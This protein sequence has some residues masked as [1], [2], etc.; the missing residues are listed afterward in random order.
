MKKWLLVASLLSIVILLIG[1]GSK[2]IPQAAIDE[3]IALNHAGDTADH[4][5]IKTFSD[6]DDYGYVM[7]YIKSLPGEFTSLEDAIP[8][9][10][11]YSL[12]V[13]EVIVEIL[14]KY[15]INKDLS[16]W[17]QLPLEDGGV[18]VLGHAE[19][20]GNKFVDFERHQP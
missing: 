3:V 18:T 6:R 8:L 12:D 14:E 9:A 15:D 17:A 5:E 4:V 13:A 11:K 10:E 16:V 2:E 1:C 7:F 19:Y 20:D